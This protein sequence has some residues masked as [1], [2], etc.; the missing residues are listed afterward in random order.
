MTLNGPTP[1]VYARRRQALLERLADALLFIPATEEAVY[2]NDVHFPFRQDTDIR[3]LS[4]FEE[5]AALL[6]S[7]HGGEGTG[8]SLSVRPRDE[9]S[10]TWTGRRAGVEGAVTD[11]NADQ[12]WPLELLWDRLLGQLRQ[13]NTLYYARSRDAA[14]NQRVFDLVARVNGERP[15]LGRAMLVVA[16]ARELLAPMRLRKSDEEVALMREAGRISAAAHARLMREI[17]PGDFEYQGQA[18][19]DYEFRRGGCAGPAYESIVAGGANAVI[20]HYTR[21][22]QPLRAGELVLVDAGGEFGGYCADITRTFPVA[23]EFSPAQAALYDLVLAA[24]EAAI[25]EVRTGAPMDAPHRRAVEV[26]CQGMID[27][28]LLDGTLADNLQSNAC[29]RFYMHNTSHWLGM[30]VHDAGPYR[31]TAGNSLAL[32]PGMV[33]TIEPGI[34]IRTDAEVDARWRGIG[35]RIE[36]DV[37]V[38]ADGCEILTTEAPKRRN[39][40]EALRRQ[41]LAG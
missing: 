39:D 30:E 2:A 19:L 3:Y 16:D 24:Q 6:L 18:L 31:D 26:L 1:Q 25:A 35:I 7:N 20:L 29:S 11:Y 10:E 40:I 36:D 27:L 15:R 41:A 28:G 14:V 17:R 34:Y 33:L 8:F 22:D 13:V 4:G 21:N 12:A 5:P 37:V 32:E 23:A 9:H 38:G